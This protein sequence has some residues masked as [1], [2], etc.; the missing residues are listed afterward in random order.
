MLLAIFVDAFTNDIALIVDGLGIKELPAGVGRDKAVEVPHFPTAV[1]ERILGK[2]RVIPLSRD[3]DHLISV[4]DV[5]GIAVRPPEGAQVFHHPIAVEE[6]MLLSAA[7]QSCGSNH[8]ACVVDARGR[9]GRSPKRAKVLH[10]WGST[11]IVEEGMLHKVADLRLAR[12]R[13]PNY[14]AGV[15]DGQ[16]SAFRSPEG[17]QVAHHPTAVE[18]GMMRSASARSRGSNHLVG[19]VDA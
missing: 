1:E 4:V 5:K 8:L 2:V 18:E 15:I 12:L 16:G 6:G 19:F 11:L 3:S 14:L 10:L 13:A 7:A 17:A 9:A